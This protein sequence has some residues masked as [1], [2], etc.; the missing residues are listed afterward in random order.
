[1]QRNRLTVNP[2]MHNVC[3]LLDYSGLGGLFIKFPSR[4]HPKNIKNLNLKALISY[5]G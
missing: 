2:A 5:K 1:M 4:Q 3:Q